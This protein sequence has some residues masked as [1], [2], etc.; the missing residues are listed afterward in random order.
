M[1]DTP[2]GVSAD[3]TFIASVQLSGSAYN[4]WPV[5]AETYR[6]LL[7]NIRQRPGVRAAGAS[8][9]L[10][11]EPGWPV[12]FTIEGA[13]PP[14]PNE[15]PLAQYHTVTDGYFE[16][17]GARMVSGRALSERD[18]A[19]MPG[20]VVVNET[21]A[22]RYL[23]DAPAVGRHL[24]TTATGIG[25]LGR[26]I[27]ADGRLEVVGVV[28]DIRNTL[29]GQRLE[30]AIYFAGGQFPFRSMFMAIDAGTPAAGHAALQ[31]ALKD[32]APAIPAAE[33]G[34]WAERVRKHSAEPRLLMTLLVFFAGL[35]ALLAALGVY[36]LFS[37]SVALR[38]RELAIRLTLGARP[39]G[40]GARLLQQAAVL[41][42]IGLS[43]GWLLVKVAEHTLS[44]VLFEVSPND[45]GSLA[46]AGTLL[47]VASL[48]ACIAPA[49]RAMTVDPVEGLRAE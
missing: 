49:W 46:A 38:Q 43:G 15:A 21:L 23:G 31:G 14:L 4:D 34:S 19:D 20:A 37:W 13:P 22:K 12:P 16:A 36:G 6:A 2:T 9:F 29:L 7:A 39:A 11:F 26:R 24:L 41:V 5:V 47:L 28:A 32:L 27:T 8:T 40:V 45:P 35:A 42:V 18:K 25:P 17:M 30:P 44:R 33:P 48:V 10:P 1:T 3:N